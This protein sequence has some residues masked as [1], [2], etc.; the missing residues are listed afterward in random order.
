MLDGRQQPLAC[1]WEAGVSLKPDESAGKSLAGVAIRGSAW[2]G[3]QVVA[4][5]LAA[6]SATF[7]LGFLLQAPDFGLAWFAASSA[8]FVSG[9]HVVAFGDVLLSHPAMFSR[10]APR[11]QR[12]AWRTALIQAFVIVSA[13]VVL[14]LTYP[15]R[16]GIA[17]LMAAAAFRPIF[18]A[19]AVIP[20]AAMRKEL[21]FRELARID[22][23]TAFA[24]SCA[25]VML[26]FLGA[27]AFSIL[28]PP[29]AIAVVRAIWYRKC[30][31]PV[32]L[33]ARSGGMSQVVRSRCIIAAFG[34][35]V[36]GLLF[37][38]EMIVLGAFVS[39]RSLGLYAFA[40]GLATQINSI[41][42]FQIAGALLPIF[43]LMNREPSRQ[44]E[45]LMRVMRLSSAALVPALLIQAALG[46]G[47]LR[48]LWGD[49]WIEAES[50]F[51][52]ISIGQAVYVC[53]WPAAFAMKAQG[54]FRTYLALQ[55][56]SIAFIGAMCAACCLC[57]L[58]ILV[59]AADAIAVD[60]PVDAVVP[61][62]VSASGIV[63]LSIMS[64]LMVWI[65]GR[66][67]RLPAR[68]ALDVVWR[69]MLLAAPWS[70]AAAWMADRIVGSAHPSAFVAWPYLATI[71]IAGWG[72]G[73]LSCLALSPGALFDARAG[74]GVA[75][76]KWSRLWA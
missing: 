29:I 76:A 17:G 8:L 36:A 54:R 66:P 57:P 14:S 59:D 41:V 48:M 25:S 3:V 21:R 6:A 75:R 35:Y 58:G 26:A 63:G 28:M 27:G 1:G 47:I 60:I 52:V 40:F 44:I 51:R 23:I 30:S 72:G 16:Q 10:L 22:G 24:G 42:S 18:D 56:L 31:A 13:G 34:S 65:A 11:V 69:P 68:M 5:K 49:K 74:L 37:L 19:L 2:T 20:L 38:V 67:V 39:P 71:A 64:P 70:L 55:L 53:Q 32:S 62:A 33:D 15:E 50:I 12:L 9:L 73:A 7:A 4:N 45:A 46:P 43:G 61:V